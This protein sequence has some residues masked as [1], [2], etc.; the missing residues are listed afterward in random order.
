MTKSELVFL[1]KDVPDDSHIEVVTWGYWGRQ[2]RSIHDI[3]IEKDR[4]VLLPD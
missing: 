2:Y 4:V 1:L 3:E